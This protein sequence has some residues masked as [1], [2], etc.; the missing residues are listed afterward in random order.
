MGQPG[1]HTEGVASTKNTA[2]AHTLIPGPALPYLEEADTE[3]QQM[4]HTLNA[5]FTSLVDDEPRPSRVVRV[6][7]VIDA[8]GMREGAP[9]R[10]DER[11][12]AIRARF[13]EAGMSN[14]EIRY[15]SGQLLR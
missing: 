6:A 10:V 5:L 13:K 4:R 3:I 14:A 15:Y 9:R 2:P 7:S 1:G 12:Q 8:L 11:I